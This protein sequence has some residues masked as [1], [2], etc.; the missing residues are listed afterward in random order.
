MAIRRAS[1][2]LQNERCVSATIRLNKRLVLL[3][4]PRPAPER[5]PGWSCACRTVRMAGSRGTMS[6]NRRHRPPQTSR[7]H[8]LSHH[9]ARARAPGDHRLRELHRPLR[10]R[11]RPPRPLPLHLPLPPRHKSQPRTGHTRTSLT[12]TVFGSLFPIPFPCETASSLRLPT[13]PVTT[14]LLTAPFAAAFTLLHVSARGSQVWDPHSTLNGCTVL[15]NSPAPPA[16]VP[17]IYL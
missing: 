17:V 9:R 12:Q 14:T 5:D 10:Q 6:I 2:G 13:A 4:G 15:S 11:I 7:P 1:V 16:P 3:D 8:S